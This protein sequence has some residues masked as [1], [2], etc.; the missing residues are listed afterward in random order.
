MKTPQLLGAACLATLLL[1][2]CE[3]V[4]PSTEPT[5]TAALNPA[6]E[7]E[8]VY[9]FGRGNVYVEDAKPRGGS[10]RGAP[11]ELSAADPS[12]P[13][14]IAAIDSPKDRD[15]AAI[16]ALV[17]DYRVSFHFLETAGLVPDYE[18]G[19]PYHSWATEQVRVLAAEEDFI[20]L[21]HTL[22]MFFKQD[23]GSISDPML[24]KH[25]RQDWTYEDTDLH[26]YRGD[27]TWARETRTPESVAGAWTQSVWQVDDS[28]RYEV[29]GRWQHHG[30]QSVWSSENFWRP[31]PRREHSVRDD[32]KVMEGIHRIQLTPTGWVH[33]Q[34][35]LK[36]V[37][38][39]EEMASPTYL[40]EEMGLSHY[41]RIDTPT[42][43]AAD[44]YW[45]ETGYYWQEVRTAWSDVYEEHDRF[46]LLERVNEKRLF[47]VHFAYAG[48]IQESD[49]LIE[50]DGII[51]AHETVH[52]FLTTN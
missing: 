2:G 33:E 44:E 45:D 19:R 20:S 50:E 15:R 47:E 52:A 34:R 37:E 35:S 39:D 28:P 21:Q 46:T 17:G 31:L 10:S 32:Y 1:T 5:E 43:A 26:T 14:R 40:A 49:D 13:A 36:R 8:Q 22:V 11:F 27:N 25:W 3:T 41:D 38:G 48:E 23:D 30:N 4:S 7:P 9:L 51:H 24:V 18:L 29:V 12:L 42:L 6:A 16:L